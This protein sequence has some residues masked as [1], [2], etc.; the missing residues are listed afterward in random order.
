MA[1]TTIDDPSAFFQCELW[2]GNGS[3][4]SITLSGNSDLQPDMVWLKQRNG[5]ENH[6]LYDSVRGAG[7]RIIPNLANSESTTN[8]LTAFNSDGF[9]IADG[10]EVNKSNST[11]V[12]WNWKESATAG[13][14]IVGW[15]G[16]GSAQ[17]ISHNLSKVP[18]MIIVKNRA[19]DGA[20]W[21]VYNVRN[22][23]THSLILNTNSATVGE[24][25]DNWNDTT[26]TSSVFTV[27]SSNSTGGSSGDNMIAYVFTDIQGYSKFG[28]YIGNG[29]VDGAFI[30][31]GFKP[32]VVVFKKIT[33]T[34]NWAVRD[35]K[36]DPSNTGD[37]NLFWNLGDAESSSNG[38][39][40]L[41]NGVKLRNAG[42][43]W[44]TSNATYIYMAFAEN[45]FVTSTGIPA[46][47]K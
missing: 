31:T 47:A 30:Y 46:T 2:T 9:A 6:N 4:R 28:N 12:S 5:T 23:N 45:P 25:S 24:Y 40:F 38:V 3:A 14:D 39:D 42:A 11:Y 20:D 13:F 1:Y 21:Y 44:N 17:N 43:N 41:S 34:A 27:G 7:K 22:N 35:N 10:D 18:T 32:A 19:D 26:P 16:N 37:S 36:R 33:A 15:T 8:E 29:N